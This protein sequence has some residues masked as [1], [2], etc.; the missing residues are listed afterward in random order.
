MLD[1]VHKCTDNRTIN[2]ETRGT[3]AM[4]KI[5]APA[6][7]IAAVKSV[8]PSL[9]VRAAK[10]AE[11]K[12]AEFREKAKLDAGEYSEAERAAM[13]AEAAAAEVV[14]HFA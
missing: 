7:M 4:S 8:R 9:R 14:F 6:A 11:K 1:T 13:A 2:N 3:E 12:F 10:F 5:A